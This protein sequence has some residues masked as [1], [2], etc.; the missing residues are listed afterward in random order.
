MEAKRIL[1]R[2]GDY[3]GGADGKAA[4]EK[5]SNENDDDDDDDDKHGPDRQGL[6]LAGMNAASAAASAAT[7]AA[8]ELTKRHNGE[9]TKYTTLKVMLR[10]GTEHYFGIPVLEVGFVHGNHLKTV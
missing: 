5:D 3:A 10:D 4:K 1:K 8:H 6:M 7:A 9:G 2:S